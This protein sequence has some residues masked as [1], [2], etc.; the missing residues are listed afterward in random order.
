MKERMSNDPAPVG[1]V[2][3]E[4]RAPLRVSAR[5]CVVL[6]ALAVGLLLAEAGLR[7]GGFSYRNLYTEDPEVGFALR[8]GADGSGHW[9][10]AGHRVV[11]DLVAG[12]LCETL[13]HD[14]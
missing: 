2:V 7:A 11:G 3:T 12:R 6:G 13:T 4:G 8:P 14:R 9:N 5:V 1:G 10:S